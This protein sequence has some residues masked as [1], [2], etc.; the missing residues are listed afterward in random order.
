MKFLILQIKADFQAFPMMYLL[1][2]NFDYPQSY[3]RFSNVSKKRVF[4]IGTV[5]LWV[6]KIKKWYIH[7]CK[8]LKVSF[9]LQ[10]QRFQKYQGFRLNLI[11]AKITQFSKLNN[12]GTDEHF[13]FLKLCFQRALTNVMKCSQYFLICIKI[14]SFTPLLLKKCHFLNST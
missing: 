5:A 10:Y 8:G 7:H 14:V 4:L 12:F 9:D 6:F 2:F 13:F 11:W 1:F 3:T